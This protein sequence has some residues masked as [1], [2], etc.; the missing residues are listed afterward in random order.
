MAEKASKIIGIIDRLRSTAYYD[1]ASM[2]AAIE[3]EFDVILDAMSDVYAFGVMVYDLNSS[4]QWVIYFRREEA[5][6]G[7]VFVP[8]DVYALCRI[9][10]GE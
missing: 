5:S 10:S 4:A 7:I 8:R 1:E 6:G 3:S 9:E 2:V